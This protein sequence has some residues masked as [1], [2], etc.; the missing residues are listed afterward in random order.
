MKKLALLLAV[1]MMMSAMLV[2]CSNKNNDKDTDETKD[3]TIVGDEGTGTSSGNNIWGTEDST[4]EGTETG[5][6]GT[7]VENPTTFTFKSC[8]ETSVFTLGS[9]NIRK[10]ASFDAGVAKMSVNDGTELVKIAESNE[11]AIDSEGNEYKW[12]KVKYDDAEWYVKSTLVTSMSNPDDGFTPVNKTLYLN[13]KSLS[14]RLYPNTENPAVGY[15]YKG[16]SVKII[17]ENTELGWYKIDF[18]GSTYTPAGEYYV[19]SDAKYFSANP[20]Q[21]E[22]E[23]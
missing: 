3:P 1:L 20:V 17:A 22:A 14:I 2:A 12:F 8:K 16:D 18:E 5:T 11:S 15:L 9:V 6:T 13:T 21:A 7:V 23:G 4:S 19:V 10:E